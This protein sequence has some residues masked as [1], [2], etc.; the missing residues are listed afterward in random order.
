MKSNRMKVVIIVLSILLAI[1]LTALGAVLIYRYFQSEKTVSV[2][3]PDNYITDVLESSSE[4]DDS[5]QRDDGSSETEKIAESDREESRET[6]DPDNSS[7]AIDSGSDTIPAAAP[8]EVKAISIVLSS[9]NDEDNVPFRVDNMFPGDRNN[10]YYQVSV[11]HKASV[12][13]RFHAEVRPGYEKLAEVLKCRVTLVGQQALY[14]G[15]MSEMPESVIH[16][17][18]T[19]KETTSTLL[20]EITAY[21]DTS[22]G[23]DYQEKDLIADFRWWV[24]DREN[25]I[26]PQTG[27]DSH[28]VLWGVIAIGS[29]M[30]ILILLFTGRWKKKREADE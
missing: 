27:D 2:V 5:S 12:Q 6:T 7:D 23:N 3:V 13:V 4:T 24:E 16:T 10:R 15:L 18:Y 21:L 22:V 20:Y 9:R 1:S 30:S 29:F 11:S 19:N 14:D 26:P 25:L 8:F 17:L 28:I